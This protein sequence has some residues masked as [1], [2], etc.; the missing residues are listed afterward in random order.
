M[1]RSIRSHP[2]GPSHL[3]DDEFEF[4]YSAR[5]LV[6]AEITAPD[7]LVSFVIEPNAAFQ[8]PTEPHVNMRL[9]YVSRLTH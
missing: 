5:E 3:G 7:V 1:N 4:L 8:S 2:L 9:V 6:G